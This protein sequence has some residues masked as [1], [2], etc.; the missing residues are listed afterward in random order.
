M[1]YIGYSESERSAA[2]KEEG[3]W[4]ISHCKR[5][6]KEETGITFDTKFLDLR[7]DPSS[8]HHTSKNYNRTNFYKVSEMIDHIVNDNLVDLYVEWAERNQIK[9]NTKMIKQKESE[10]LEKFKDE[11]V[12]YNENSSSLVHGTLKASTFTADDGEVSKIDTDYTVTVDQIKKSLKEIEDLTDLTVEEI[13]SKFTELSNEERKDL[14]SN[15]HLYNSK[16][17]PECRDERVEEIF[18][19]LKIENEDQ[20]PKQRNKLKI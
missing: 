9:L 17:F 20:E 5:I 2:A 14:I 16:L 12:Y 11:E 6:L 19:I 3:E 15:S 4:P 10:F 8:W 7:F 13:Y 1:G 18:N